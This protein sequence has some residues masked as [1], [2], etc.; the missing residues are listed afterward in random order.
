[1]GHI[2][3]SDPTYAATGH[4]CCITDSCFGC[5]HGF[6][7][8]LCT[9]TGWA[10]N[11]HRSFHADGV[12]NSFSLLSNRL[13]CSHG[14][15]PAGSGL[16]SLSCGCKIAAGPDAAPMIPVSKSKLHGE[17]FWQVSRLL[18][19]VLALGLTLVP[20]YWMINTS[21]KTQVEV[22]AAP[23]ALYPERPVLDNYIS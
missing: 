12:Q 20:V 2:P 8:G 23:P 4:C 17:R 19:L 5:L 18:L 13:R 14:N 9:H 6:R 1:M 11:G 16:G 10:R 22:F 7:P 3:A 15:C 21:L